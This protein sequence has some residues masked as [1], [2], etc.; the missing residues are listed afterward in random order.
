MERTHLWISNENLFPPLLLKATKQ[1]RE[2]L[3]KNS[4][5]STVRISDPFWNMLVQL[6]IIHYQPT[7]MTIWNVYKDTLFGL[8]TLP[9]LM[10]RPSAR[11]DYLHYLKEE[12]KFSR[13]SSSTS[14]QIRNTNYIHFCPKWTYLLAALGTKDYINYQDV[15]LNV[16]RTVLF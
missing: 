14:V 8:F 9:C 16:A 13:N 3:L 11:Q 5:Y 6:S 15:G 10:L 1:I 4:F 7:W 12:K 2:L